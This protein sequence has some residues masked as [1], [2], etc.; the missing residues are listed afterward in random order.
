MKIAGRLALPRLRMLHY[1]WCT[2]GQNQIVHC[3]DLDIAAS[4]LERIEAER[5]LD[6][7][8]K[9]Y[10]ECALNSG[11]YEMLSTP[12]PEKYWEQFRRGRRVEP[13]TPSI[14]IRIPDLVP[15]ECTDSRIPVLAFEALAV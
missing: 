4:A 5:R 3:L 1:L 14:T 8:V 13:T 15:T 7:L 9:N 6:I 2:S 11:D 10:I 12:S